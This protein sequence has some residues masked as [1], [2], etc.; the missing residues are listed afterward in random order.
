MATNGARF[1][2]LSH[3]LGPGMPVYPGLPRPQFDA[4]MDHA[5]SLPH[6]GGKAEFFLG[7][8]SMP[9]N[10]GTY[11]DSPFHRYREGRDLAQIPIEEL[12]ELRTI[13]V[14]HDTGQREVA[15]QPAEDWKGSALLIRTG[16]DRRWGT[17]S[18]W[19]PGPYL[20]A[21]AIESLVAAEVS[22][23]GVDFWNIDNTEDPS[24]PAHTRLLGAGILIVEHLCNLTELPERGA[25]LY[26]P[27]L[28]ITGGASFPVR[29]FA[30]L[31]A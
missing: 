21:A 23:V 1:V 7:R 10:L 29:A 27:V 24:R 26:V 3:E 25:E 28:R 18:Y 11:V 6:Y 15:L 5:S 16:W 22:V 4:V 2:D 8:L 12:V 17:D 13:V 14:D 30:R 20:G 9:T 31:P 19:E